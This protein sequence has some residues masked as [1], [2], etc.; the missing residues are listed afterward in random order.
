MQFLL[1]MA[2]R[3]ERTVKKAKV[4]KVLNKQ[5]LVDKIESNQHTV[6][7]FSNDTKEMRTHLEMF[8]A[9]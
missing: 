1:K 2:K 9:L 6:V 5:R 4:A 7:I 8:E 3:I